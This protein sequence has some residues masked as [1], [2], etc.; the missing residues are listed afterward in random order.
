MVSSLEKPSIDRL[1][2]FTWSFCVLRDWTAFVG[3]GVGVMTVMAA[4]VMGR[5]IVAVKA[6]IAIDCFSM[7]K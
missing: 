2:I 4:I 7:S 1:Y 3:W 6:R 5:A